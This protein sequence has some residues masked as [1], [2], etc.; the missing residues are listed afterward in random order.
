MAAD[1]GS[2]DKYAILVTDPVAEA[3]RKLFARQFHRMTKQEA[4]SR[5]GA[6]IEAV[7][8][9]RVAIRRMRS[10]LKLL[11]DYYRAGKVS[12]L[13]SGLREIA[14]A[15]GRIR[16]LDVLILD[17]ERYAA[18]APPERQAHIQAVINRL[19]R[20][21]V[22][23]RQRLNVLLD[24]K[25][26]GRFLRRLKRF[27]KTRGKG[28]RRIKVRSAPHQVRHV[29]PVLLHQGLARVKAYDAIL[30]GADMQELHA[31][32]VEFKQLRYAL[33]F[34]QPNLGRSAGPFLRSARNMQDVLG[35]INDIAVFIEAVGRLKKLSPEEAHALEAY[36]AARLAEQGSLR[37]EF[38]ELWTRFKNRATQRQFSDSLLVL[39]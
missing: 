3:G 11:S 14:R 19:E 4:G 18:S 24:S 29:L 31:L 35:R 38:D 23:Q 17:L 30:P 7:H 10:L 33:E 22:K 32:R 9:M 21:R 12:K 6:D 20:R 37:E 27:G 16:D 25:G 36:R 13:E 8:R 2:T 1:Q 5:Q 26:Y 28:A 15:L 34:F 39:R